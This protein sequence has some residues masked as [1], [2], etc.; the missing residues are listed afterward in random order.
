MNLTQRIR[1]ILKREAASLLLNFPAVVRV[2]RHG[3]KMG[4]VRLVNLLVMRC[5]MKIGFGQSFTGA[6]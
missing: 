2:I 5:G 3:E 4:K 1:L 6:D